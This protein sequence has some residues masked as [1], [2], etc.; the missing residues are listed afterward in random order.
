MATIDLLDRSIVRAIIQGWY[1]PENHNYP[2]PKRLQVA[3]VAQITKL[4]ID[5]EGQDHPYRE[6]DITG[7]L[8]GH[9]ARR[10]GL[11]IVKKRFGNVVYWNAELIYQL[12]EAHGLA[13]FIANKANEWVE[14]Q[15]G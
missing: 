2:G 1:G 10:L 8:V 5:L 14:A 13:E 11:A 3:H 9:R 6:T 15:T 4:N 12:A 7:R